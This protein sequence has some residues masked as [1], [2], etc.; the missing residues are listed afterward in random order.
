MLELQGPE[1]L[2]PHDP[3]I[4]L[5]EPRPG[6]A[7]PGTPGQGV[8]TDEVVA[9]LPE[10]A[11]GDA[12]SDDDP[13]EIEA[14]LVEVAPRFTDAEA[15]ALADRAN[16]M[17]ANG[18][19]LTAG[20]ASKQVDAA[21]LRTWITPTAEDGTLELTIVP[22]AVNAA[23]P[24]IFSDLSAEPKNASFDLQNGTPV[25]VPVAAGRRVLRA[26]QRRPRLA[27]DPGRGTG[28]AALEVQVTEPEIT[29][30]AAQVLGH[31][32]ARRRQQRLA[33][34]RAHDR[35]AR[36]SR[37]TTTPASARVTNIHR[38]ADIVRGT[39]IPPGGTFSVNDDVGQRTAAK[40]FV[41]GRRHPR[42]RA[43]RGDR[44][45]RVAVRHHDVQRRLLRR[46][47]HPRLPGPHRVLLPLPPRPRGHDG[48]PGARPADH[49]QHAL[50][51]PDLDVVHATPA[52]R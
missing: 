39:V 17:T 31:H 1:L 16:A 33:Q 22:D 12:S 29:T 5:S 6:G 7:V 46:P 28:T 35:R 4:Q 43:R 45:R 8:D 23:I 52:S 15:Q 44:R 9:E 2:A 20:D 40:G 49:Q 19:T 30:E 14:A 13:I 38:I 10:A 27:G 3:T 21:T 24:Q 42:G 37:P 34:R 51:G 48:L 50:R 36:A 32:A 47:R 25:V 41:A 11:G 18:L 26:N